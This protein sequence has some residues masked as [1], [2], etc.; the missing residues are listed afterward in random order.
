MRNNI[1]D[2]FERLIISV[3]TYIPPRRR[4]DYYLMYYYNKTYDEMSKKR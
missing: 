1:T 2:P 4:E 3:Y